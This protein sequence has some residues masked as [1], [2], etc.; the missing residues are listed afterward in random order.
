MERSLLTRAQYLFRIHF[1]FSLRIY[2]LNSVL[3]GT[4]ASSTSICPQCG[5]LH[6]V[7]FKFVEVTL[8]NDKF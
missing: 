7:Q 2:I 3:K 1:I 6:M 5:H 8:V 4:W